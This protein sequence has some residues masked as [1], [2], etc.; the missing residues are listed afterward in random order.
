MVTDFVN[1][2]NGI[3]ES[4]IAQSASF[5]MRKQGVEAAGGYLQS[6]STAAAGGDSARSAGDA[7]V[8]GPSEVLLPN[9]LLRRLLLLPPFDW[10]LIV[11]VDFVGVGG[12]S[13]AQAGP[14]RS[15]DGDAVISSSMSMLR[16]L[17]RRVS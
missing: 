8:S 17:F 9:K 1:V 4:S 10:G 16:K 15:F 14:S 12:R 2:M 13:S 11:D 5:P 3:G 6:S 7:N